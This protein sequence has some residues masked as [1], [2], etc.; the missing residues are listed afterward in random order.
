[1][2]SPLLQVGLSEILEQIHSL[3]DLSTLLVG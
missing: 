3:A 2:E 1:V